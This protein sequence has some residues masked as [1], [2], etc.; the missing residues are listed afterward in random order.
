MKKESTHAWLNSPEPVIVS[1]PALLG[2]KVETVVGRASMTVRRAGQV[3]RFIERVIAGGDDFVEAGG[4]GGSRDD[5]TEVL[6]EGLGAEE[7]PGV[8]EAGIERLFELTYRHSEVRKIALFNKSYK[9][10]S[11]RGFGRGGN[12]VK[13]LGR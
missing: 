12:N 10:R 13:G 11:R 8:L 3:M 6:V 5:L 7:D 4:R 2:E 9:C 1:H